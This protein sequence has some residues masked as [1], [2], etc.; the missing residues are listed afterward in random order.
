MAKPDPDSIRITRDAFIHIRQIENSMERGYFKEDDVDFFLKYSGKNGLNYALEWA[1]FHGRLDVVKKA[2]A[3]G[4]DIHAN[5][6]VAFLMASENNH[7]DVVK[8]LVSVDKNI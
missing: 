6:D 7:I 4:A 2:I 3:H 8:Y 1:A 5:N